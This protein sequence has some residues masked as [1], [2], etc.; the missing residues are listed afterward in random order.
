MKIELSRSTNPNNPINKSCL[1]KVESYDGLDAGGEIDIYLYDENK[2]LGRIY[3]CL[4]PDKAGFL[5]ISF[6]SQNLSL[7]KK[8]DVLREAVNYIF[9]IKKMGQRILEIHANTLESHIDVFTLKHLGFF[10]QDDSAPFF[11]KLNP[12][13]VSIVSALAEDKEAYETLIN[14]YNR[15]VSL[16][17]KRRDYFSN[18]IKN[19]NYFLKD[20]ST[21]AKDIERLTGEQKYYQEAIDALGNL[22][23]V[24]LDEEKKEVINDKDR[25]YRENRKL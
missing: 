14:R 1:K 9:D 5:I 17:T 23:K 15:S 12:N 6:Y 4:L 18:I 11:K 20:P 7:E 21:P 19:L 2:L 22:E 3:G 24:E 25:Y 8:E 10:A 13:Y 16:A